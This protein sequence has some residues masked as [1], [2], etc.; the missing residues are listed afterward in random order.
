VRAASLVLLAAPASGQWR[1]QRGSQ[2]PSLV[3]GAQ[4]G[5]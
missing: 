5:Q 4:T 1:L 3:L 2:S